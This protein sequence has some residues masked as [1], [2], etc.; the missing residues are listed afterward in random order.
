[1]ETLRLLVQNLVIIVILAVLLEMLLPVGEMRRFTRMVMG[2]M[3]IVAVVQAM[4][5]LSGGSLFR[6]I[7]DYAWRSLHGQE[8]TVDILEE[9]RRLEERNRLLAADQYKKGLERQILALVGA[10]GK[11]G[12]VGA[13]LN[14]QDDPAGKDFGRIRE[15]ILVFSREKGVGAVEPVSVAVGGDS[16][17]PPGGG[18]PPPEDHEDAMRAARIVANFYNLP[19]DRVKVKFR[20]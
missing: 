5:G 10:G 12:L 8:K 1:M 19:P 2:L 13:D 18:R 3:V 16:V 7:E 9:G 6:E 11:A 15:I 4:H 17:H 20:D 14:I